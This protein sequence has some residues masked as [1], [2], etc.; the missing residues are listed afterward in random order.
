MTLWTALPGFRG[1]SSERTWLYRIAH[2][3]AIT[4]QAKSR[5]HSRSEQPLDTVVDRIQPSTC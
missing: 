2:N 3:V 5:R 4:Y 1:A